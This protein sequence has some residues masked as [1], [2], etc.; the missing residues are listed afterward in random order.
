M[1]S[2]DDLTFSVLPSEDPVL[3]PEENLRLAATEAVVDTLEIAPLPDEETGSTIGRGWAFDFSTGQFK[4]HGDSPAVLKDED[5]IKAWIEKTMYTAR[6]AHPIYSDDYG[7]EGLNDLIARE[8][9]GVAAT[10]ADSISEAL[11]VHDRIETVTDFYFNRL[12][13][14]LE[15]TFV[16]NLTNGTNFEVPLTL[17]GVV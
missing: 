15:V 8:E 1:A 12:D 14:A 11:L 5:Q 4:R 6:F 7:V 17:T 13:E 9:P 3:S 10:L 2:P 16:V